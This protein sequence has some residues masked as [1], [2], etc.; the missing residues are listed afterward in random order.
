MTNG[1]GKDMEVNSGV[2][3]ANSFNG[4]RPCEGEKGD[5]SPLFAEGRFYIS[6]EVAAM[7]QLS[8]GAYVSVFG[9]K[10]LRKWI[11][12]AE[13]THGKMPAGVG[14]SFDTKPYRADEQSEEARMKGILLDNGGKPTGSDGEE[15]RVQGALAY[16]RVRFPD[17]LTEHG[18]V[19]S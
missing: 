8:D 6:P 11:N 16:G 14:L 15:A 18:L 9:H 3:F 2:C 17:W 5:K 4:V 10:A 12:G 19:S 7:A 1:N 13:A